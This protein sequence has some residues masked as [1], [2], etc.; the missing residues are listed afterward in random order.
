MANWKSRYRRHY[1]IQL[2]DAIDYLA[3]QRDIE[4]VKLQQM[5]IALEVAR[6]R[7]NAGKPATFEFTPRPLTPAE[8]RDEEAYDEWAAANPYQGASGKARW[9]QARE[10]AKRKAAEVKPFTW[11]GFLGSLLLRGPG[12]FARKK[13]AC[14][15]LAQARPKLRLVAK[16]LH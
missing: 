9:R 10:E 12:I 7:A 13:P 6:L 2:G 14:V 3:Y 8:R 11:R 5:Q 16:H 15:K 1:R 4:T